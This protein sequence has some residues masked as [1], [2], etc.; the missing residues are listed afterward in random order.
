MSRRILVVDDDDTIREVVRT[1]LEVVAGWEVQVASNGAEAIDLCRADPPDA[2]ILDVMMPT[3]DGPT[4]VARLLGDPRTRYVP[5][6]L[7]TAKAQAADLRHWSDLG[8][9]GVIAKPFDPLRLPH[10]VADLLGWSR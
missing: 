4:T 10:Q 3:M 9:A 8:V 6:V 1:G 7:L 2:V 5:V